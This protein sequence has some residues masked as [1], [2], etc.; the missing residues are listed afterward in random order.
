MSLFTISFG[1]A[2][3]ECSIWSSSGEARAG[4]SPTLVIANEYGSGSGPV[5]VFSSAGNSSQGGPPL[6]VGIQMDS[7]FES[8]SILG[9]EWGGMCWIGC[10]SHLYGISPRMTIECEINLDSRFDSFRLFSSLD[11]L[12]VIAEVGVFAVCD[13]GE[14]DWRVDLDIVTA[15]RWEGESV[16]I[17]QMDRPKLRVELRNGSISSP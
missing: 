12:I 1:N 16:L 5:Y 14:I 17:S 4:L 8:P 9:G 2:A 15:V 3:M 13:D 11:R 7:E 6:A 10:N